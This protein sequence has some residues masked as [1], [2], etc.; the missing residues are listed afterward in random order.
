MQ[1]RGAGSCLS[2][3]LERAAVLLDKLQT[4]AG[5]A[6]GAQANAA[7]MKLQSL[8]SPVQIMQ[9]ASVSTACLKRDSPDT[10]APTNPV[11]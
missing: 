10:M 5:E 11:P 4:E 8:I 9:V 6:L 1:E 7:E 3:R 2:Y